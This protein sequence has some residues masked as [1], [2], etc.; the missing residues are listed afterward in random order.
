MSKCNKISMTCP[1]S[2]KISLKEIKENLNKW[3]GI[4]C[5]QIGNPK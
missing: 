1:E 4:P 5:S 2:Y 3:K